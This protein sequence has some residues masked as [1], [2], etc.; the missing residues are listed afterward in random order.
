MLK[1]GSFDNGSSE[2]DCVCQY[3]Y[4]DF[5]KAVVS[6]KQSCVRC[7]NKCKN[8]ADNSGGVL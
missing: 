4:F 3:F 1:L 7:K 5:C 6:E 2:S 8:S